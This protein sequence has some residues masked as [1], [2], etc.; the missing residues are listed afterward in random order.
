[1]LNQKSTLARL[2]ANE[3]ITV[4][5]GNYETAFFDVKTRTLGL[6]L[7][8]DMGKDVF[9][10]LVGH[11]VSH[12]LFTPEN[13]HEYMSEGIP[14]SWLNIVEDVR[15]EKLILR[16]YPGL[17]GNF[18]RG[19]VTLMNELDLFGVKDKLD[20][21]HTLHFMDR[22]NLHAK[23]RDMIEVP[24]ADDELQFVEQAK[25]CETYDDVVQCC[26]DIQAWLKQ[27][28]EDQQEQEQ[29]GQDG[30]DGQEGQTMTVGV[31]TDE[32][33][34]ED[35]E[36]MTE[37][38]DVIIDAREEGQENDQSE[39]E[40]EQEGE[41][42][43]AQEGEG[44]TQDG[45]EEDAG[46][47]GD[48]E[49]PESGLMDQEA[50]TDVNY[51]QNANKL[52]N[53]DGVIYAKGLTKAEAKA[54]TVP[55]S[56]IAQ[57][58][59][60]STEERVMRMRSWGMVPEDETFPEAKYAEFL[61]ET[62]QVVNLM[63]KEFE[64][65]KA[66]YR[67]ARARTS[68]RGTLDVNKLHRYKYDD[69]LFKQA[70][71]LA[72]AKSHGMM[73]LVDYSGSMHH[74][75]PSVLRQTMALLMFCKRVGIPFEVY[76]FTS[77]H[78]GGVWQR[79]MQ[80]KRIAKPTVT[81][82]SSEELA[83]LELFNSSMSKRD[84]EEAM[85]M[86]F[87][88]TTNR[89]SGR[90]E[91]EELGNTP[92]NTALM[93][94]QYKIEEFRQKHPVQKMNFVTLTDGDSNSICYRSGDDAQ[95]GRLYGNAVMTEVNGKMIKM[96]TR[97]YGMNGL[98]ITASL[99]KAIEKMGCTTVNYFIAQNNYDMNGVI[100]QAISWINEGKWDPDFASKRNGIRRQLRNNGVIVLDEH[101]GYQRRFIL[102]ADT[103]EMK[104]EVDGLEVDSDMTAKKIAKAFS[105]SNG[106]KKK[107]RVVTQ[108]FAELVA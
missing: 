62:K 104:G 73:M 68:T 48:P 40:E 6:P 32:K 26:R 36:E 60:N 108:K 11:E 57:A 64:M 14:H 72:D 43:D 93:A 3:N 74:M 55:Y 25:A 76:A 107:S 79:Y 103:K 81:H 95:N 22:L 99:I 58:R 92:L 67:S 101:L 10:M 13:F 31:L 86:T 12:A 102:Q 83:L 19:Y 87:W 94:M 80:A 37:K 51:T 9:D 65:R 56:V 50:L 75:L 29:E 28:A 63:V 70:R 2:L 27:K 21:I 52:L 54:S 7:W 85:R 71:Q 18:K 23:A 100:K 44:E 66:A 20:Q 41:G 53:E 1:M 106:S 47:A 91:F 88:Q 35:G 33:G 24:F 15:I 90:S 61:R 78:D 30:D 5:Q 69:N 39:G 45:E 8:K 105:K 46:E 82:I 84:Y 38:P 98:Q 77:M 96:P 16:K 49:T 4:Q 97:T 34:E 59:R 17:V 42:Q 89:Y